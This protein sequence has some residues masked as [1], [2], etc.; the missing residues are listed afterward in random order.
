MPIDVLDHDYSTPDKMV[1]VE[2]LEKES[3]WGYAVVPPITTITFYKGTAPVHAIQRRLVAI[4]SANPWLAGWLIKPKGSKKVMLEYAPDTTGHDNGAWVL[5]RVFSQTP[6]TGSEVHDSMPYTSLAHSLESAG[7]LVPK[8]S[9][10]FNKPDETLLRVSLLKD[11]RAPHA[12]FALVVSMCHIAADGQTYY[13]IVN[14]LSASA[15]VAALSPTRK[16]DFSASVTEY[17]GQRERSLLFGLPTLVNALGT[18]TF[19]GAP[20][21]LAYEV[22]TAK[23]KAAKKAAASAMDGIPFVS[24]NDVLTSA[25]GRQVGADI[26]IMAINFRGRMPFL[27]G[28]DAGNYESG[29]IYRAD[30]Y[31]SPALI[32]KSLLGANGGT[33]I[34]R[35]AR[36]PPTRLPHSLAACVGRRGM[37]TNWS[38]FAAED[39]IV[40]EGCEQT[41]HLPFYALSAVPHDVAVIFSP[42]PRRLGV[43]L[44]TRAMTAQPKEGNPFTRKDSPFGAPL[45]PAAMFEQQ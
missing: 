18:V 16:H 9:Q 1:R 35:A 34:V 11:A 42:Q 13:S 10:R 14:Q 17:V 23:V 8:A 44:F 39:G 40:L 26:L 41:L 21:V 38:T 28:T 19:G 2:L 20:K 32:R 22:D 6:T 43:L 24:T 5:S 15:K 4:I 12:G 7:A 31:A 25:I 27:Q 37:I 33:R 29:I 45:S 30:D 36:A 3:H